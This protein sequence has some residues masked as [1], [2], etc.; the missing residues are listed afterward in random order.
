[1]AEYADGPDRTWQFK[2]IKG[3]YEV[4]EH[5]LLYGYI[6]LPEKDSET[7]VEEKPILS[8]SRKSSK[9]DSRWINVGKINFE[10]NS[11]EYA[12]K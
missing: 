5:V 6:V 9:A 1:V 7:G 11:F 8:Y 12:S 4:C 3:V 2:K 10:T